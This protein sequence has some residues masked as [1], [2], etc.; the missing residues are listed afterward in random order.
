VEAPIVLDTTIA[1]RKGLTG[2]P[3]IGYGE[4]VNSA[5]LRGEFFIRSRSHW[6][7]KSIDLC[8]SSRHV[9]NRRQPVDGCLHNP[10]VLDGEFYGSL[11]TGAHADAAAPAGSGDNGPIAVQADGIDEAH[12]MGTDATA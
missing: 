7:E 2:H 5:R 9:D 4:K 11:R 10:A 6:R 3:P 12:A 1:S 8:F